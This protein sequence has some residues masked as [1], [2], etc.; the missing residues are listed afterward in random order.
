MIEMFDK[1][2][3]LLNIKFIIMSATLPRL[4]N[5]LKEKNSSFCTLISDVKKYYENEWFKNRVSL[6]YELLDKKITIEDLIKKY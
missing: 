5:L 4:D 1:Y 3:K 6:N 2:A